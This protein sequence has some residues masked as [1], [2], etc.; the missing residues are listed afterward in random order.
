MLSKIYTTMPDTK[1]SAKVTF[2]LLS[3][4]HVSKT[5][6]MSYDRSVATHLHFEIKMGTLKKNSKWVKFGTKLANFEK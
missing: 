1:A 5:L 4:V 2:F 3:M 6:N